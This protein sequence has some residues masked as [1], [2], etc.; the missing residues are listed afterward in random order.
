MKSFKIKNISNVGSLKIELGIPLMLSLVGWSVIC[1]LVVSGMLTF[2]G[3]LDATKGDLATK[4]CVY[5]FTP[6][7][8]LMLC[9]L[10]L[11]CFYTLF[12]THEFFVTHHGELIHRIYALKIKFF[13]R[14]FKDIANVDIQGIQ[15][16][17][18][19]NRVGGV[20]RTLTVHVPE[21]IYLVVTQPR[22]KAVSLIKSF[23]PGALIHLYDFL[24]TQLACRQP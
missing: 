15:N 3:L 2:Q 1:F 21:E 9:F 14:K 16:Y 22:R 10:P 13:E 8:L 24:K 4:F 23:K 20:G 11:N 7:I 6:M 17:T 19:S 12:G 5:A 18:F